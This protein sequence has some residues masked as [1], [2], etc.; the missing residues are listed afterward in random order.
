MSAWEGLRRPHLYIAIC[1]ALGLRLQRLV[2]RGG[3]AHIF[4]AE[5]QHQRGRQ[6]A[7]KVASGGLKDEAMV[8]LE[9]EQRVLRS[10]TGAMARAS[11][12]VV[13][14]E[15]DSACTTR[16]Q[17][18][19]VSSTVPAAA[20]TM[21]QGLPQ[22]QSAL[23][24]DS[25]DLQ[26]HTLVL[27][28]FTGPSLHD[29][30]EALRPT[31][32]FMSSAIVTTAA[33]KPDVL[34]CI[35]AQMFTCLQAIHANGWVFVDVR[36]GNFIFHRKGNTPTLYVIDFGRATAAGAIAGAVP[37][38]HAAREF[39]SPW[40]SIKYDRG[41]PWLARDDFLAMS[42]MLMELA[43]CYHGVWLWDAD[44]VMAHKE[45]ALDCVLQGQTNLPRGLMQFIQYVYGLADH[46]TVDYRHAAT[47]L[48]H[49]EMALP[50]LNAQLDS[51]G[52]EKN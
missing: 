41:G 30:L 24:F 25:G 27:P 23:F 14:H 9:V 38:G 44:L 40:S 2:A 51:L 32:F 35:A 43:G 10:W 48:G 17:R 16:E 4:V 33:I 8:H 3:F 1:G 12:T 37:E 36:P 6:V 49:C 46:H 26:Y 29:F 11:A 13:V 39:S 19:L 47:F 20:H 31:G 45:E 22:L 52:F 42:L 7:L 21:P 15:E 28:L 50:S 18:V 5:V 34:L